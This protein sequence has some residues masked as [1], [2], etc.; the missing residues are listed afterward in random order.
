MDIKTLQDFLTL[1]KGHEYLI[2][3]GSMILFALFWLLL[4]SDSKK[5]RKRNQ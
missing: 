1:T 3:V 2:A 4:N 5:N